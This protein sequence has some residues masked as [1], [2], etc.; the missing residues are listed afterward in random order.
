MFRPKATAMDN[1]L[2]NIQIWLDLDNTLV[3]G[4]PGID[5]IA[6][7]V[8]YYPYLDFAAKQNLMLD[9]C[10]IHIIHPGVLELLQ[11]LI[12]VVK[13]RICF[14]SSGED[15][16]NTPLVNAL[17]TRALGALDYQAIKQNIK[18]YSRY[19]R[20]KLEGSVTN[21]ESLLKQASLL[22]CDISYIKKDLLQC[23]PGLC[24]NQVILIDDDPSI[25]ALGQEKCYL[26]TPGATLT[27]FENLYA[28]EANTIF[29]S[30]TKLA[31]TIYK[32][33]HIFYVAGLLQWL[34]TQEGDITEHLFMYQFNNKQ[35]YQNSKL[36]TEGLELLRRFN[37]ELE[38]HGGE[39]A[40]L[41]LTNN[42]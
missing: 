35:S 16:R 10:F 20:S 19:H 17:L 3:N 18:I 26:K 8:K 31:N 14:F 39:E 37:A 11:Y 36:Y 9:A 22:G 30:Q 4:L 27:D 7:V 34:L 25:I 41:L 23:E 6:Q 40:K 38:F 15:S 42:C 28:N 29:L 21:N 2:S 13:A 12:R 32:V 24:L 1:S 5:R 33:N